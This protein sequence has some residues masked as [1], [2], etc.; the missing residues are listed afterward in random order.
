MA[1]THNRELTLVVLTRNCTQLKGLLIIIGFPV[2]R[3]SLLGQLLASTD[4]ISG[5][6]LRAQ[7][8]SGSHLDPNIRY[9]INASYHQSIHHFPTHSLHVPVAHQTRMWLQNVES[10]HCTCRCSCQHQIR[11]SIYIALEE[12]DGNLL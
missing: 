5:Y 1:E 2:T 9:P 8:S 3:S 7:Y 4:T 12:V 10:A 6:K 11:A